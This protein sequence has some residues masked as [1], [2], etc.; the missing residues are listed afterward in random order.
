MTRAEASF[1]CRITFVETVRAVSLAGEPTVAE[2]LRR[3]WPALEVIDVDQSLAER[4]AHLSVEH[5]LRSLDALHLAAALL[6]PADGL[7][8]S[9]WDR[10]LHRAAL[11]AGVEVLPGAIS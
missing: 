11:A 8:L 4:A 6:L 3:D 5:S 1:T 10:R 9:T 7:V 2:A